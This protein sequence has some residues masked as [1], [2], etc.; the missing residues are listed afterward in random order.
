MK[1]PTRSITLRLTMALGAIALGVFA[2]STVLLYRTLDTQLRRSDR[3]ALVGMN[4]AVGHIVDESRGTD[5]ST[6]IHRLDDLMVGHKNLRLWLLSAEGETLFG[7]DFGM[8]ERPRVDRSDM[9]R[10]DRLD[11][12]PSEVLA[13][14]MDDPNEFGIRSSVVAIDVRPRERLLLAYRRALILVS[15]VGVLLTL[16]LGALA[17]WRGLRPL[18]RLSRDAAAISPGAMSA[19]LSEDDVNLEV[20]GLARA[21]NATLDRIEFAYRQT[22]AF[23][24]D[25]AHELRTPLATLINGTQ[26]MLS[27]RR[28]EDELRDA[29]GSNLEE[30][31]HLKTLVNDMLFLAK[32]DQG[33]QAERLDQTDLAIEA[34]KTAEYFDAAAEAA[35]VVVQVEGTGVLWCD[36]GLIRR[37]ISNLLSNAVKH[38]RAGG[39]IRIVVA[40]QHDLTLLEVHN[41]GAALSDETLGRMFDRFFRTES[42]RTNPVDSHGL[43]L[44]I[45]QAIAQ[46]HRGTTFARST[47]EG[48]VVGFSIPRH[49]APA[50]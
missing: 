19:R 7:G 20:L 29:L 15:V 16:G 43:G 33:E 22:E 8:R 46:M 50:A 24:A 10:V 9:I 2:V 5:A 25:V 32:A 18:R 11:G 48:N 23:N 14:T 41:P 30:L 47:G 38:T 44:S 21:F 45:V 12:T 6:L 36:P 13:F 4:E 26:V 1:L 17:V 49:D 35:G 37:A 31:E 27:G 34:R 40:H 28:T 3:V 39:T 42:A